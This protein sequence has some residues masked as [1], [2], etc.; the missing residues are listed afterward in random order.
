MDV[1]LPFKIDGLSVTEIGNEA[2]SGCLSLTAVT[3]PDRVTEIPVRVRG[4]LNLSL[5]TN[6]L[7]VKNYAA[8]IKIPVQPL[9][10]YGRA[11]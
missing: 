3:I 7:V 10:E 5:Y 11:E 2:F 1:V 4:C 9:K 6:N 8:E